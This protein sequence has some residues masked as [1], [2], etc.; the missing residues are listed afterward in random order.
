MLQYND[1]ETMTLLLWPQS[2][3]T[4]VVTGHAFPTTETYLKVLKGRNREAFNLS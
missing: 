1:S 3:L 4:Y 2:P